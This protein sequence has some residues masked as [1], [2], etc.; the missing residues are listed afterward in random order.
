MKKKAPDR[1]TN[2][3]QRNKMR[4]KSRHHMALSQRYAQLAADS[5]RP[6]DTEV[7]NQM[8]RE[9]RAAGL[10]L[11]KEQGREEKT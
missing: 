2:Q 4:R 8:S 7:L 10:K 6:Y 1:R 3:Q 5:P 9:E 11:W